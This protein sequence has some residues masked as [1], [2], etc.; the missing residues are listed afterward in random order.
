MRLL[1]AITF[2]TAHQMTVRTATA[3]RTDKPLLIPEI[4]GLFNGLSKLSPHFN[5]FPAKVKRDVRL[6]RV[7]ETPHRLGP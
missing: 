4:G 1:P 2:A 5:F 6:S 7:Y 3:R